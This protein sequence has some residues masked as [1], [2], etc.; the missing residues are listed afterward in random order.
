MWSVSQ[1]TIAPTK[2]EEGI[3]YTMARSG[4]YIVLKA[5]ITYKKKSASHQNKS[6]TY[7]HTAE[8]LSWAVCHQARSIEDSSQAVLCRY[9]LYRRRE[10]LQRGGR[11][12]VER[13]GKWVFPM[14][15]RPL[16]LSGPYQQIWYYHGCL[17]YQL[18]LPT[19]ILA[20][21]GQHISLE[22]RAAM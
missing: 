1:C 20:P 14:L 11:Q 9:T 8:T 17:A 22:C 12:T 10:D 16:A 7:T 3:G 21:P 6:I 13:F 2:S 5:T 15:E 18:E 19:G 4:G